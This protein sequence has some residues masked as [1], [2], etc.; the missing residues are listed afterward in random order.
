MR[1]SEY[2]III[3]NSSAGKDSLCALYE[4]CRMAELQSFPKQNIIVSH[5]DLG[6]A[7]WPGTKELAETQA[8]LFGL[9]IVYSHRRNKQGYQESLLEYVK[10]RKKWPSSKQRYCTSDFKRGPGGRVVTALTKNLTSCKVLY[11]FGFRAE[12][13]PFRAKKEK[14][15]INKRLTNKSRIVHE[16]NPILHWSLQR[17]WDTIHQQQLPYHYAYDLGMTRL[18][19]RFCIFAPFEELVIS[20]THNPELLEEYV[21]VEKTIGHTFT[22]A[23]SLAE[24]K[25][26]I[27]RRTHKK[28]S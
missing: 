1:L 19:C 16:Y 28:A 8:A 25:E 23:H 13:S 14:I 21:D 2:D 5:Q 10:R 15:S 20:G 3:I 24:V 17:V 27:Q 26:T 6:K 7:K 18:S 9:K 22:T 4:I 11:V 12:E